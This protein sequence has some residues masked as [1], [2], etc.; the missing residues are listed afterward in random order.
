M[1]L[2][3]RQVSAERCLT[4]L[5][6]EEGEVSE[7]TFSAT[8]NQSESKDK[9]PGG[10]LHSQVSC[11]DRHVSGK[12]WKVTFSPDFGGVHDDVSENLDS[13]CLHLKER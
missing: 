6:E 2:Q 8:D 9:L 7:H 10:L 12:L 4:E 13:I 1:K 11:L 3:H 5:E